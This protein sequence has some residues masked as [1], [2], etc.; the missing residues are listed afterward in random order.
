MANSTM[1]FLGIWE[2]LKGL[3]SE[4]ARTDSTNHEQDIHVGGGD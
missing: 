1:D 2:K 4:L 3:R